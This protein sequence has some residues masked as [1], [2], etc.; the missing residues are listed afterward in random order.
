MNA[1]SISN[2]SIRQNE[3]VYSLLNDLHRASYS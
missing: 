1:I 3:T 2:V